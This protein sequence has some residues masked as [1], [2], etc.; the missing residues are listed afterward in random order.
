MYVSLPNAK[1][2]KGLP[3]S[4]TRGFKPGEIGFIDVEETGHDGDPPEDFLALTGIY[5][6]KQYQRQGIGIAM[7]RE[8]LK[9]AKKRGYDGLASEPDHRNIASDAVWNGL[10][11]KGFRVGRRDGWDTIV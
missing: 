11:R 9:Q 5:L 2:P 8:A 4:Y 7:Y 10:S 1:P 3:K 6:G